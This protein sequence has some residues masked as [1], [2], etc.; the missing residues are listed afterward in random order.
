MEEELDPLAPSI[1]GGPAEGTEESWVEV[2]HGRVLT[3][4]D[5]YAVREDSV[6]LGECTTTVALKT[7]E[8]ARCSKAVAMQ[9]VG[10]A[11]PERRRDDG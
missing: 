8:R 6:S 10:R 5:R 9:T 1:R 11:V 7:V 3:I 4:E 2:G